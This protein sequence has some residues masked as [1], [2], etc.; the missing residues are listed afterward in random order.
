MEKFAFPKSARLPYDY[1]LRIPFVVG[2]L[3]ILLCSFPALASAATR[4]DSAC[5]D[6]AY[7]NV[8][9]ECTVEE[10]RMMHARFGLPP[11][12]R[13]RQERRADGDII[14]G[15]DWYKDGGGTA[16]IFLRDQNGQPWVEARLRV[17]PHNSTRRKV[18]VRRA[19]I[20]QAIWAA[21]VQKGHSLDFAS[22]SDRICTAGAVFM[23]EMIDD[24][25]GVRTIRH[26]PCYID[27]AIRYFNELSDV[28][29]A[30]LPACTQS[31]SNEEERSEELLHRCLSSS[32]VT[33][34]LPG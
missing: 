8:H 31:R 23:I 18:I 16:L 1:R 5:F 2:S 33:T 30:A 9:P 27:E 7:E 29:I 6:P 12:E 17:R 3:A 10:R 11:F 20:D 22:A 34:R 24:A 15:Y 21:I 4:S 32:R 26:D 19:K 28:A 14:V 13:L 25:G